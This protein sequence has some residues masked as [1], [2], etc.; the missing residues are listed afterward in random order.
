MMVETIVPIFGWLRSV[1]C[2]NGSH[3]TGDKVTAM[4]ALFGTMRFL[5]PITHPSSVGFAERYVQLVIGAIRLQCIQHGEEA[6]E[7]WGI[8]V[9]PAV[10]ALNTRVVK[11]HGYT[12][13]EV[14]L[15]FNGQI[16]HENVYL[17]RELLKKA[18]EELEH[19][20]GIY[21]GV[22]GEW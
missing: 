9:A 2:D 20:P 18:K 21:R 13:P 12:P 19:I 5:A 16:S 22:L 8:F 11:G 7:R 6:M 1:Y 17:N 3:F 14:L 15:G 10:V 4:W